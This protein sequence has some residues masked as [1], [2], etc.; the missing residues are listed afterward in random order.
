MALDL[1]FPEVT[2]SPVYAASAVQHPIV[3]LRTGATGSAVPT[4]QF[5]PAVLCRNSSLL[6]A[7]STV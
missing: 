5:L 6:Y 3:V 4:L 2:S 7:V 1:H